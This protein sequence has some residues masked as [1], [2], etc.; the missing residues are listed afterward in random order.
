M[1]S[2]WMAQM[3]P[4]V[5]VDFV[6]SMRRFA[7]LVPDRVA[8][9]WALFAGS[10]LATHF[11]S[12][13]GNVLRSH[14]GIDV[15]FDTCLYAEWKEAKQA[16]LLDQ[17]KPR[18][19]VNDVKDLPGPSAPNVVCNGEVEMLPFCFSLDGG[20]P[21]TSRTPVIE[22]ATTLALRPTRSRGHRPRLSRHSRYHQAAPATEGRPGVCQGARPGNS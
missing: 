14:L 21:C 22:A 8:P 5:E 9:R 7:S 12:A 6:T 16:H 15:V 17:F 18:Y 10:G 2:I 19:M 11:Y 13:L 3:G 4:E 20:P 1:I